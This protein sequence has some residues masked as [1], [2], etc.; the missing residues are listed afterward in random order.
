MPRAPRPSEMRPSG[1]GGKVR[2]IGTAGLITGLM[3]PGRRWRSSTSAAPPRPAARFRLFAPPARARA[4]LTRSRY[5][6][7]RMSDDRS[8]FLAV[9]AVRDQL[10]KAELP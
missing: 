6:D 7:Q 1:Q 3:R 4:G 9:E 5:L 10:A 8:Q 2:N